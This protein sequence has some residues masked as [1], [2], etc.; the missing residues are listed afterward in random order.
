MTTYTWLKIAC[1][2]RPIRLYQWP[3]YIFLGSL[4]TKVQIY[5]LHH[6]EVRRDV[7]RP[8]YGTDNNCSE[9]KYFLKG[10]TLET[11]E[12]TRKTETSRC[13]KWCLPC[14]IDKE[15]ENCNVIFNIASY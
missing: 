11:N 3:T 13:H 8:P 7:L 14:K 5:K 15:K 6:S 2:Y 12:Y 1:V 4:I 10:I 9:E